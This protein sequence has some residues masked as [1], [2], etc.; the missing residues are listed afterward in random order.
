MRRCG[1]RF[2]CWVQTWAQTLIEPSRVALLI[3][4]EVVFTAIIAVFVGQ[5]PLTFAIIFGGGLLFAAML[6]VEWPS[7]RPE[8]PLEPQLHE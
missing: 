6:V 7:K 5:E 2:C 1:S 3:T 8:T 4:S